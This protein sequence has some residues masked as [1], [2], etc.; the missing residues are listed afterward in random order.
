MVVTVLTFVVIGADTI[1]FFIVT[2]S[3]SDDVDALESV[4]VDEL[5]AVDEPEV[6]LVDELVPLECGAP[7]VA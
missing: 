3:S 4:V 7:S 1:V 5:V 6:V 2:A